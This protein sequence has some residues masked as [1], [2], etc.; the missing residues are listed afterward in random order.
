MNKFPKDGLRIPEAAEK[1]GFTW[2]ALKRAIERGR[3]YAFQFGIT[4][5][6][7]DRAIKKYLKIRKVNKIPKSYRKRKRG[8]GLNK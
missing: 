6:T 2:S 5:Y 8:R 1:Y 7:T 3:L 4:W